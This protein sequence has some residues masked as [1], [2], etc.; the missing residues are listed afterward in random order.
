MNRLPILFALLLALV[1]SACTDSMPPENNPPV[2]SVRVA[3]SMW[4]LESIESNGARQIIDAATSI[5]LK[6]G[7]TTFSG[8]GPCNRHTAA[9]ST[10]GAAMAIT[11]FTSGDA[12]CAQADLEERY[13]TALRNVGGYAVTATTLKLYASG[14]STVLSYSKTTID[15]GGNDTIPRNV[16]PRGKVWRLVKIVANGSVD[17]LADAPWVTLRLA[18]SGRAGGAGPCS[19]Y[20]SAYV[21]DSVDIRFRD[22]THSARECPRSDRE[23]RYFDALLDAR[24]Y[25]STETELR[26]RYEGGVL[27]YDLHMA[28]DTVPNASI[29]NREWRLRQIIDGPNAE[30]ITVERGIILVFATRTAFNGMG[31]CNRYVGVYESDGK[32][33]TMAPDQIDTFACPNRPL[34]ERYLRLLAGAAWYHATDS[35]LRIVT[36]G[37]TVLLY[38]VRPKPAPLAGTEW[39]LRELIQRGSATRPNGLIRLAFTPERLEGLSLCNRYGAAY[40]TQMPGRISISD[41]TNTE[42]ACPERPFEERYFEVLRTAIEFD[43][44]GGTLAISSQTATLVFDR[45]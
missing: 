38:D 43:H 45:Q 13:F 8:S 5:T 9:Y 12:A 32:S 36:K 34:E 15:P 11:R 16:D 14:G 41:W 6:F 29:M 3:G 37:G 1:A 31:P 20:V 18:E 23:R 17:T 2:D 33:L 30:P 25:N 7:D 44:A 39:K 42:M 27:Q 22:L 40:V 10:D 26:I 19:Q 24:S 21:I 4:R 35:S 28:L